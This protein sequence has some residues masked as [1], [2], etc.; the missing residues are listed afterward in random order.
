MLARHCK[1]DHNC[2]ASLLEHVSRLVKLTRYQD[3]HSRLVKL[4]RYQ[5]HH[6][7]ALDK[8]GPSHSILLN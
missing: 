3:H 1:P 6:I 7:V 4:I 5:D 8:L 2:S